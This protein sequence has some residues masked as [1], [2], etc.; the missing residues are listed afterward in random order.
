MDSR[1]FPKAVRRVRLPYPAFR[2]TRH[3]SSTQAYRSHGQPADDFVSKPLDH[4]D[5]KFAHGICPTCLAR[6]T[7]S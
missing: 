7:G 5:L 3:R 2:K 4:S 6:E 1:I